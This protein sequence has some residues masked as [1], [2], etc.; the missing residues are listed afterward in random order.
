M[1][2]VHDNEI[3]SYEVD[4]KEKEI[5]LKTISEK[6]E[7]VQVLF[8][9]V[10]AHF[11]EDGGHQ[12]IIFDIITNTIEDFIEEN[13]ELLE[14]KQQYCWP[15]FFESL[16]EL[17]KYLEKREYKYFILQASNGLNG[18]VLAKEIEITKI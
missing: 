1:L 2:D 12:N 17:Q 4:F 14:E 9:N 11:F 3:V 6:D 7:I 8:K 13:G 10:L 5:I 15:I 18:W 16:N